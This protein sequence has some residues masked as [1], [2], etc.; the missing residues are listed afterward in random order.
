MK[1]GVVIIAIVG[2]IW[3]MSKCIGCGGSVESLYGTY[4]GTDRFGNKVEIE[5]SS[6]S[7]DV[8]TKWAYNRSDN[9][10]Y[11][12]SRG[13]LCDL[14]FRPERYTWNL[15]AGYVTLLDERRDVTT[16]IDIKRKKIYNNWGDYLDDRNGFSY[17]FTK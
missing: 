11:Y 5:L 13:R 7:D 6:E 3:L 12:D 10:V 9:L 16:V 2:A 15:S 14:D 1:K 8:D 4:I 17:K